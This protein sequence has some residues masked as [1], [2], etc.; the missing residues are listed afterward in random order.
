MNVLL[1]LRAATAELHQRI[2]KLPFAVAMIEGRLT[3][4]EYVRALGQL[5]HV[6][7]ALEQ[8]FEQQPDPSGLWHPSM[9]RCA[10]L[11]RD[12][13]ALGG[14]APGRPGPAAAALALRLRD[15]SP[16]ARIGTLYVLE[17][18]RMGSMVLVQPLARA[19]GVPVAP[20]SGLDYHLEGM[21]GRPQ[22]WARF[23]ANLQVIPLTALE[24]NAVVA[25][26]GATMQALH[27]LYAA[28]PVEGEVRPDHLVAG[29]PGLTNHHTGI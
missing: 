14:R 5:F 19:L 23:K 13:A 6:H 12:L 29:G 4:A 24:E 16:T 28:L 20:D 15:A 27:D 9:A 25:L 1:R 18:S 26:A 2:E 8:G 7:A 10:A 22:M 17:G 21:G 3:R 11:A